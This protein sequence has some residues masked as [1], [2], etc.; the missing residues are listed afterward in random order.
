MKTNPWTYNIKD[1]K[2]E[3]VIASFYEKELLWSKLS[4]IYHPE[5][6]SHITDTD[7]LVLD[8]TNYASKK[9]L[10]C[11][12]GVDK[13]NLAAKKDFIALKADA[14]KLDTHKLL[15][16]FNLAVVNQKLFL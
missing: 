7:K 1:V 11:T 14:D 2:G 8:L 3:K 5:W 9:E 16:S 6:D 12:T 15:I 10:Q 13:S 4:M